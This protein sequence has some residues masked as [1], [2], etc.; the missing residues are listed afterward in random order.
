V[1]SRRLSPRVQTIQDTTYRIKVTS[2][3]RFFG[4]TNV[5]RGQM[6][7]SMSNPS[8]TIVDLLDDPRLGGGMRHVAEVVKEYFEG[9]LRDD[10]EL[11]Q[12]AER[13]GN[14]TVFKR[15]GYLLESLGLDEPE[16]IASCGERTSQG[17]TMLDPS[18]PRDGPIVRRWSLRANVGIGAVSG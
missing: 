13:L 11:V 10:E 5:W 12:F 4:L 1:T 18:G 8:R 15:M 7:V 17:L 3:K 9:E 2:A 6:S 16:L 14:H